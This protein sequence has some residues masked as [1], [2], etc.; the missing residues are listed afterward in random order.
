MAVLLRRLFHPC[1]PRLGDPFLAV[2][3]WPCCHGFAVTAAVPSF[4]P[5]LDDPF[6]AVLISLY[7]LQWLLYYGCPV[8]AV[9]PGCPVLPVLS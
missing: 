6:L 2:Q 4:G 9:R 3:L 8:L 5:R 1:G 7:M